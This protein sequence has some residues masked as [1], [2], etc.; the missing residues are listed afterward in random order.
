MV[1]YSRAI[2]VYSAVDMA[3]ERVSLRLRAAAFLEKAGFAT[4]TFAFLAPFFTAG[5]GFIGRSAVFGFQAFLVSL[6]LVLV[7]RSDGL[8]YFVAF[9]IPG[10]AAIGG[11]L[12]P[13]RLTWPASTAR[14]VCALAGFLSLGT[15]YFSNPRPDLL[16]GYYAAEAGFLC[17]SVASTYRLVA[18]LRLRGSYAETHEPED[19]GPA[20]SASQE[21]M[22]RHRD[23]W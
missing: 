21:L 5:Y 18:A 14:L 1:V 23:N 3:D 20:W 15:I 17:A 2:D 19:P 12:L 11:L 9:S 10:M 16:V 7:P 4:A 6:A 13:R 22:R 8:I